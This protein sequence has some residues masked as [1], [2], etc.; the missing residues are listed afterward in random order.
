MLIKAEILWTRTCHLSCHYCGMATGQRNLRSS[1]FWKVG[2][3]N[4]KELGCPFIAIYGAEPLSD[5]EKLPMFVEDATKLNI[6][7]T[8]ITAGG[9]K[10]KEGF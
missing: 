6:S 7:S 1:H 9:P 8:L 3:Q 4:L 2:L 5:F 10:W